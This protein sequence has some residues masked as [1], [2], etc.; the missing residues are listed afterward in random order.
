MK[1]SH[2]YQNRALIF[3]P[4]LIALLISPSLYAQN[5]GFAGASNR[6]GYSARGMAMGNAMSAVT[7]Q[8]R[9]P[10]LSTSAK[11]ISV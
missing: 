2:R 3:F 10:C 6:I 1:I 11:L 5:G 4:L 8:L 7:T 9:Q